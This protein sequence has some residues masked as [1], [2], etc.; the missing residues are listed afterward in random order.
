MEK[1]Y[2]LIGKKKYKECWIGET[3]NGVKIVSN[4]AELYDSELFI[5][6]QAFQDV[7]DENMK[8]EQRASNELHLASKMA[9]IK[10]Q[11]M[12]ALAEK[13]AI[14]VQ[15]KAALVSIAEE[16]VNPIKHATKT[17]DFVTKRRK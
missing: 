11:L 2:R 4:S 7:L 17:L 15:L 13:D 12:I 1:A 9:H 3:D 10:D 14:I 5:E 16:Q 8:A 6:Y